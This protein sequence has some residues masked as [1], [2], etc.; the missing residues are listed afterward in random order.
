MRN[1]ASRDARRAF[2]AVA[3]PGEALCIDPGAGGLIASALAGRQP[4]LHAFGF[5][6]DIPGS[7][8]FDP[9]AI[10]DGVAVL[11]LNGPIEHHDSVWC[12]SYEALQREVG[13]AMQ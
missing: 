11:C 3:T 10:T 7:L 4:S 8:V 9:E 2:R 5:Y 13:C 6:Y 1:R 12:H